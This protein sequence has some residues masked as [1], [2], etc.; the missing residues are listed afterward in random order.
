MDYEL[1]TDKYY[2]T[3]SILDAEKDRY[4]GA[5]WGVTPRPALCGAGYHQVLTSCPG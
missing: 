4:G 5:V 2:D 3:E 1:C